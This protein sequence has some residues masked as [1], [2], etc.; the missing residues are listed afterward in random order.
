MKFPRSM[1]SA[2]MAQTTA[3][4]KKNWRK[5]LVAS[6]AL[7]SLGMA[8]TQAKAQLSPLHTQDRNIVNANGTVVPLRGL[9]LGGLFVMEA[10]MAPLDS[11]GSPDTYTAIQTLDSRFGV[12]TEQSLISTY[13]NSWI[14]AS[15]LD[16]I[17]NAGFNV[18]RVPVWWGQFY[19]LNNHGQSGWRSDAFT[20]LDWLVSAAGARG[21]Y[22]IIDGHGLVGSQGNNQDTG[23]QNQDQYW[24]NGGDQ[25]D[26]AWMWWQIANHYNGNSTVAGYDLINE[27]TD[28][29]NNAAV[30][31]AYD[32]LYTTVR[33]A[34]A[35]H[36]IFIEGTWGNWNW[37]MLPSPSSQGWTNVVYSMHAYPTDHSASG[38]E[39]EADKQVSDF[40][41][42]SGW[43]IPG[44]IGEFTDWDNN[45][46]VWQYTVNDFNNAGLSW[47]M[48]TYK[49]TT[50]GSWGYY[51]PTWWPPTPNLE[52]DSAATIASDWQ[53]WTTS[54][55][56][57]LDT[58]K[59]IN[60]GGVNTGA[61]SGSTGGGSTSSSVNL[62]FPAGTSSPSISMGSTPSF[63]NFNGKLY[64][65]F[66]ANDSSNSLWIAS[67]TDGVNFGSQVNLGNIQMGSA[68]SLA[69]FNSKLYVAFQAND[70]S[71]KLFVSSSSDGVTF[72]AA[73]G[74][75]SIE[76]GSAPSLA[77][78]NGVLYVAFQANDPSNALWIAQSSDGVNFSSGITNDQTNTSPS[79]T[80][81]NNLLYLGFRANDS[82]NILYVNSSSNG[83]F[84]GSTAYSNIAMG[85]AP[86][87][88]AA[89]GV[90]YVAFQA[91]DS[92]HELYVTGST[93]GSG[94]P[95]ATG[96]SS[97]S[98][99]GAPTAAAFG[100]NL[101]IGF[102]ANDPSNL[103]FA[104]EN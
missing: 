70:S 56:F 62:S 87:L 14:Q 1:S 48:W 96:I 21:I 60:G 9:N 79:L 71:H 17:K 24:S 95:S 69:V 98:T 93:T 28:P 81:F 55:A 67:S 43:D 83:S 68:P 76:I 31:T 54:N 33:S 46:S 84:G 15:D 39:A 59:G 72:P 12:P 102:I 32:G 50:G 4:S 65:A 75:P 40:N 57:A 25:G 26:T 61:G 22:V 42:H 52:S 58:S 47:S 27:P 90:L 104:T 51:N 44:Y 100:S 16:N 49:S 77:A 74:Y 91:N 73:T 13:Q 82:S 88:A 92:G 66:R 23:W 5:S 2:R 11:G 103:L 53:Q 97:I 3:A 94:F 78:L 45:S 38:T 99:G 30:I 86:A 80:T 34:D 20:Y 36:I 37:D 41:A 10:W 18:I 64:A 85:S 101:S 8:A 29:P 63:A 89:N 19:L 6:V 7:L 35:N